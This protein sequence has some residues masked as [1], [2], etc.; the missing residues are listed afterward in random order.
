MD[1]VPHPISSLD[2][3]D[4]VVTT[5]RGAYLGLVIAGALRDDEV[6]RARLKKKIELYI[7]YFQSAAYLDR[8]GLPGL[9][10]SRIYISVHADSAPSMLELIESYSASIQELGITPIIKINR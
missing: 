5:D 7:G 1:P 10:K 3:Y 2:T 4:T 9:D 6:S 8:Y